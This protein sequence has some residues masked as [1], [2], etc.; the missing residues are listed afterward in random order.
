MAPKRKSV[1][2]SGLA[3]ASQILAQ[4]FK[5]TDDVNG[6]KK[7][8]ANLKNDV[9]SLKEEIYGKGCVGSESKAKPIRTDK[10]KIQKK[11]SEVR[12]TAS[13]TKYPRFRKGSK[14]SV[15]YKLHYMKNK[16][17]VHRW[18]TGVVTGIVGKLKEVTFNEGDV[19]TVD[20]DE[21]SKDGFAV[22]GWKE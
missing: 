10:S 8:I 18:Y 9:R 15:C 20:L 1:E 4:Y 2:N 13:K 14:V 21:L 3:E 12:N 11:G 7:Q 22:S 6:M 17:V 19:E 5:L 16:Q